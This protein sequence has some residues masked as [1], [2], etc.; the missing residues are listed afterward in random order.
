MLWLGGMLAYVHMLVVVWHTCL[1]VYASCCMALLAYVYML[2]VVWHCLPMCI[3]QLLY[4][5]ACLR[6]YAS[7]VWHTCLSVYASGYAYVGTLA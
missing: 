2:V 1:H 3:C 6:V 5:I 7:I 4:G